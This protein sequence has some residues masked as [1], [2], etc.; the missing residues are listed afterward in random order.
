VFVRV[1]SYRAEAAQ[2]A[3][4]DA[5]NVEPSAVATP[6]AGMTDSSTGTVVELPTSGTTATAA[7]SE[8]QRAA[9]ESAREQRYNELLRNAPG[10]AAPSSSAP[11]PPAEKPSLLER[12]VA[13]IANALGVNRPAPPPAIRPQPQPPSS[14]QQASRNPRTP[15]PGE[16]SGRTPESDGGVKKPGD[17]DPDSDTRAPQ[18]AGA[19]FTPPQ[20]QDGDE[21]VFTA[22]VNDDLSGVRSVSGVI[23]SPSGAL[24]GFACQRD[25]ETNRYVARIAVPKDAA[26]GVWAVKYLTLSDNASNSVNLNAGMGGLPPNAAFRVVSS[27]PDSTGPTLKTAWLDKPAMRAGERNTIFVQAEDDKSGV[28]LVSGVFVSPSKQAR[29]GFGCR[30]GGTGAWECPITPPACLDCGAWHLEQIQAQDKANNMATFRADNQIVSAIALEIAGEGC[31]A[32]PPVVSSLTLDPPVV[33]NA[34]TSI[35][36]VVAVASDDA[37]GVSSIS[38]QALG[39]AASGGARLYFT[40]EPSQDGQTFTGR[41]TVPQH[42]AKGV[43]TIA[44]LQALDKGHNLRAYSANDPVLARVTFRVE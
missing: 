38:G 14:Q 13:P 12:V 25:A 44:W 3:P 10:R 19:E 17:D 18:L 42:A 9:A 34:E 2:S 11:P 36:R 35:I 6:T 8:P 28:Q 22:V 7:M 43:W 27:R 5:P 21:T 30:L 39:P 33:S 16:S 20:V 24:Q 32:A 31:D 23:A 41:I 4:V 40:F 26:E 37:C 15:Q 1:R 29:I